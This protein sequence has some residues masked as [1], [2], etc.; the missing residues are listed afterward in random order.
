MNY[1]TILGA[2]FVL[3]LILT[4]CAPAPT[5]TS[6]TTEP[7]DVSTAEPTD[8]A[9]EPPVATDTASVATDTATVDETATV[10]VPVTGDAT[11]NV[12]DV[13]GFGSILVDGDGLSL[14][15][16]TNDTQ[17]SGTSTCTGECLVEWPALTTEGDPVAGEGVDDT[18]LGTITRDDGSIQ[19]TYNGWPLYYFHEDAAPGDTNGQGLGGV[20]FLVSPTG[21]AIEQ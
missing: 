4:A 6:L 3:A 5:E 7:T 2:V 9:T 17:D 15:L 16:F 19:V 10:S 12:S 11:V 21:E 1:K 13:E 18:L 20:W 14:Y 8:A